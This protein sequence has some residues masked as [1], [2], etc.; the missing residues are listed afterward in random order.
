MISGVNAYENLAPTFPFTSSQH[1][2]VEDACVTCHTHPNEG[3]P[4]FGIPAF[5]GHTFEPT[6]EACQRC[7]GDIADFTDILAKSDF[8]GDGSIE[9]IQD[10]VRGLLDVLEQTIIDASAT[11]EARQAFTDDFV[12]TL[13]NAML[14]TREQREAGYN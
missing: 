7:H 10:E 5:T 14:S 2:L 11:P 4:E 8:D 13:G 6:V 1:I 9:G 3:D 12:G